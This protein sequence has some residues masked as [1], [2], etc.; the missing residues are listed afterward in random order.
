MWEQ[1]RVW[2]DSVLVILSLSDPSPSEVARHGATAS[3][4]LQTNCEVTNVSQR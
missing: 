1:K 2:S 4:D 3:V